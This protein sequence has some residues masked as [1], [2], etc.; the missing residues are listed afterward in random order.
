M[1]KKI[2]M[3]CSLI[4]LGCS[5]NKQS[6]THSATEGKLVETKTYR[7]KYPGASLRVGDK[8]NVVQY[9]YDPS[10]AVRPS[11]NKPVAIRKKVINKAWVTSVLEDNNYEIEIDKSEKMPSD[12]FIE[13]I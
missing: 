1:K 5:S 12:S 2:I 4:L 10:L 9:E 8:L 3:A 11:R 7:V 6:S 13:K